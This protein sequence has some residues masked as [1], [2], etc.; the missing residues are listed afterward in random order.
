MYYFHIWLS[1]TWTTNNITLESRSCLKGLHGM[2]LPKLMRFR[3]ILVLRGVVNKDF[4]LTSIFS[5]MQRAVWPLFL[6]NGR[7]KG[8]AIRTPG[9]CRRRST[10]SIFLCVFSNAVFTFNTNKSRHPWIPNIDASRFYVLKNYITSKQSKYKLLSVLVILQ[11]LT[12][13]ALS[14]VVS[15]CL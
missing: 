8:N 10:C 1:H 12:T 7:F 14:I 5:S 15:Q 9:P 3:Q 6:G 13:V 4:R 2:Y 11:K